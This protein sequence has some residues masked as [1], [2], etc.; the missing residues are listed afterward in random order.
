[1]NVC[2]D[3]AKKSW[4]ITKEEVSQIWAES[5]YLYHKGE[6]L[7]L[8]GN[9]AK[10]AEEKQRQAMETDERQGLVE[11][12]L[13]TLLPENWDEMSLFE[14]KNFLS[15]DDFG[16]TKK[17]TVERTQVSNAEIWCECF[18]NSLSG[19]K[20]SDSYAIAAIMIK[21]E[22]WGKSGKRKKIPLYG[23]QRMY[24]KLSQP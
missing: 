18:G 14:R 24:E 3:S 21:I 9:D 7:Y 11:D 8:E 17:G 20:A 22:G 23:Q 16:E 1:M 12:Y 10:I 4:Q 5:I 6:K 2:G 13:Y 15:G 19:I